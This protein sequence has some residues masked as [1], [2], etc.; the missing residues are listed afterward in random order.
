MALTPNLSLD[1][2]IDTSKVTT[3][4]HFLNYRNSVTIIP[5]DKFCLNRIKV[6]F[7][8]ANYSCLHHRLVLQF[9]FECHNVKFI[10]SNSSSVAAELKLFWQGTHPSLGRKPSC[11]N[12][13]WSCIP[14]YL[15]KELHKT[16]CFTDV[17]SGANELWP[18]AS[19]WTCWWY[20]SKLSYWYQFK[21]NI[22]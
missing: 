4:H 15:P 14:Q 13:P 17:Q 8:M 6:T 9:K 20:D 21:K 5:N 1:I 2:H 16:F 7:I 19:K 22:S 3:L 10:S 12:H 18:V 11:I